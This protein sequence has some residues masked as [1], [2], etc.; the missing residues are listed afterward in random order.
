MTHAMH[1]R[2]AIIRYCVEQQHK[3]HTAKQSKHITYTTT[4][5]KKKL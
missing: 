2:P 1:L 4:N 3:S 5:H